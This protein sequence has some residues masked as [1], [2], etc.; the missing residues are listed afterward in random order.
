PVKC[1]VNEESNQPLALMASA[2]GAPLQLT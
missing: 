2:A 1:V